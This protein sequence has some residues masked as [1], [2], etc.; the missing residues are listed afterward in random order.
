MTEADD[1][2]AQELMLNRFNRL[3]GELMRGAIT[4]NV[5]QPW[6]I[7]L[8]LDIGLETF[9]LVRGQTSNLQKVLHAHLLA[10]DRGSLTTGGASSPERAGRPQI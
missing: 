10:S 7:D 2:V 8:L 9:H 6:E 5:F 4:R 3:M 1:L